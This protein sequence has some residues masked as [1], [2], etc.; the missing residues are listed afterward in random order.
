MATR[1]AARGQAAV[2]SAEALATLADLE[3]IRSQADEGADRSL[4][5]YIGDGVVNVIMANI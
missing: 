2:A 5:P 4:L 3:I 1:S